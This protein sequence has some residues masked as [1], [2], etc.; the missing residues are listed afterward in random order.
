M[1]KKEKEIFTEMLAEIE[2]AWNER[3]K[4]LSPEYMEKRG[5]EYACGYGYA[6]IRSIEEQLRDMLGLSER[7]D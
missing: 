3:T 6:T 4:A 7:Y 2:D 1:T 5:Y